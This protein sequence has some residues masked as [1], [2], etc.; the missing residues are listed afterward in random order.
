[1][2]R[3]RLVPAVLLPLL[4]AVAG[5]GIFGGDLRE[6]VRSAFTFDANT[7]EGWQPG[8]AD[9]DAGTEPA[10]YD[11]VG[12]ARRLPDTAGESGAVFLASTNTTDD[13]F[14]YMKESVPGLL[15][16]VTY[17]VTFS[18]R[19]ASNAPS[20]CA[21]AGGAPGEAVYLK[22]G[23]STVEPETTRQGD[24]YRLNV[25]IGS[26]SE[27]GDAT[28]VVGDIANGAACDGDAPYRIITRE[29]TRPIT[30]EA[31]PFGRIWI[32]VG[33]DSGFEGR[34]ELYV[35]ELTARFVGVE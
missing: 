17:E 29:S 7:L 18:L 12:E 33:F 14:T 19:L 28:H 3:R 20:G 4:L 9:Y 21:G 34:T 32:F 16:G 25:D 15:P 24:A 13:L 6:E 35:D 22:V 23:A 2:L 26:Q 10:D 27:E 8:L 5:C 31:D 30:V 11:F 1:M